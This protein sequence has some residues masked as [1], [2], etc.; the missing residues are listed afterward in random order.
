MKIGVFAMQRSALFNEDQRLAQAVMAGVV[1]VDV[2]H[3][4]SGQT[5][6][7]IAIHPDFAEVELRENGTLNV[8]ALPRYDAIIKAEG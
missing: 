7:F 2:R 1:V 8:A 6:A 3:D 4:P 5:T